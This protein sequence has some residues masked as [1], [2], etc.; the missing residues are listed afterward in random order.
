MTH[1]T[2][3]SVT[4]LSHYACTFSASGK[5][6]VIGIPD[7]FNVIVQYLIAVAKS[8]PHPSDAQAFVNFVLSPA[9]QAIM[10]KYQCIP[11]S[12]W[13]EL[14]STH[15]PLLKGVS[16]NKIWGCFFR[17]R[18]RTSVRLLPLP[19]TCPSRTQ[20]HARSAVIALLQKRVYSRG[21]GVA[22]RKIRAVLVRLLLSLL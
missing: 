3:S 20:S 13:M 18:L 12:A 4:D 2:C 22:T 19:T 11:A 14:L 1:P 8:S 9:E 16:G 17:Q 21:D 10:R 15:L 6:T 7:P 5:V